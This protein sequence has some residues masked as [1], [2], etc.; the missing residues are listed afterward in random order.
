MCAFWEHR[1]FSIATPCLSMH[2]CMQSLGRTFG[3]DLASNNKRALPTPPP[4]EPILNQ[5]NGKWAVL[6]QNAHAL[7]RLYLSPWRDAGKAIHSVSLKSCTGDSSSRSSLQCPGA[8]QWPSAGVNALYCFFLMCGS[9][10][11]DDLS[12]NQS[13]YSVGSEDEDEDFEERPEG[14]TSCLA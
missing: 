5:L 8:P 9:E 14:K 7:Y 4:R 10:W 3:K 1:P 6:R 12:D 13:E 11:Q 2:V